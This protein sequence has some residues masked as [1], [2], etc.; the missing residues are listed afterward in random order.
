MCACAC[1]VTS[2][3]RPPADG[4][5]P[6][7]LGR[8]S[9]G[10]LHPETGVLLLLGDESGDKSNQVSKY[11]AKYIHHNTDYLEK[12]NKKKK[13]QLFRFGPHLPS[14]S[15]TRC[16]TVGGAL[17]LRVSGLL[18]VFRCFFSLCF[19]FKLGSDAN[20]FKQCEWF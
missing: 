8:L 18:R 12:T 14:V 1:V 16:L 7:S 5:R 10:E 4:S 17:S 2:C 6:L 13:R 15:G 9:L 19:T 20:K 11:I 3:E